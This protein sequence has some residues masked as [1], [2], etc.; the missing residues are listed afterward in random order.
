[1]ECFAHS[2]AAAIGVCKSCGKGVCRAC[3]IEV[4]RG[5]ACSPQC[6][7][8]ARSLSQLQVASLRNV[9][10]LSAQRV[11]QP[12]FA[13]GFLATGSWFLYEGAG[14]IAW[15]LIAMGIIMA[16]S[17]L[18]VRSRGTAPPARADT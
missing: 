12:L 18:L 2:S 3:A 8:F 14:S 16:V 7:P 1:M 17:A 4:D 13:L 5:L 6:E 11:V 9:G 10:M 15:F